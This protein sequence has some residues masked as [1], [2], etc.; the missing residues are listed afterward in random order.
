MRK[1]LFCLAVISVWFFIGCGSDD[2][3]YDEKKGYDGK[4]DIV[5]IV[6]R[7]EKLVGV[8]EREHAIWIDENDEEFPYYIEFK[9]DGK[10]F[11]HGFDAD[12]KDIFGRKH[13][14][15]TSGNIIIV[16]VK[17]SFGPSFADTVKYSIEGNKLT[18]SEADIF[19]ILHNGVYT[20]K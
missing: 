18:L 10:I 4:T 3:G 5:D 7:D 15:S 12:E 9:S 16:D 1:V 6:E 2:K 8:W 17:A 19:S 20:R 13:T 14:W 11:L